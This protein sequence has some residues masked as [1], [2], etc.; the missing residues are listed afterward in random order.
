MNRFLC[1]VGDLV[2]GAWSE[3]FTAQTEK[4]AI[5]NFSASLDSALDY[6]RRDA[7][8]YCVGTVA[9]DVGTYR[10]CPLDAP[11]CLATGSALSLALD[12]AD[13]VGG[14]DA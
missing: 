13:K 8:L 10:V 5:R 3:P 11:R 7:V 6:I 2:S 1:V 12:K 14:D 4:E 9:V